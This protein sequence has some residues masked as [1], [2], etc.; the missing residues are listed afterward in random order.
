MKTA[1]I[2][3]DLR[4]VC[5]GGIRVDEARDWLQNQTNKTLQHYY[6]IITI[7]LPSG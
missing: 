2:G 5:C 7:D 4:L 1:Q 3:P 6:I